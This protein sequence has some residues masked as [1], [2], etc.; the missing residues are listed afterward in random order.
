MTPRPLRFE[1]PPAG[2]LGTARAAVTERTG[3]FSSPPFDSLN[4]GRS[5]P[6]DPR[7][8]RANEAAVLQALGLSE[9]VA[10]LRLEHGATILQVDRPGLQ[11]PADALL[12]ERPELILW[13]TVADCFPLF[14]SAGRVRLLAHCGWRGVAAG[15]AEA[16]V[17]AVARASGEPA[18]RQ[19]AWIGPGIGP[20]CYP[21]GDEV[22]GLFPESV[23]HAG[24][25]PQ[26]DAARHRSRG[27]DRAAPTGGKGP[28]PASG[29][30]STRLDLR[31]EITLRLRGAGIPT[32]GLAVS[33]ACTSCSRERFFSHRRDGFPSGRMAALCWRAPD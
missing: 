17:A 30:G 1:S 14:L 24:T 5:T 3:G 7:L 11:G 13:F 32:E 15:L 28:D 23:L 20:C 26:P 25:L 16:A 18:E 21:V 19:R 8:V 29:A 12:T 31:R 2:H 9:P 22:A 33:Q 6:D 10:R 4:L 27:S